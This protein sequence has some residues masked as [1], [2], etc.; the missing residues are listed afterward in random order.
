MFRAESE[1]NLADEIHSLIP[2]PVDVSVSVSHFASGLA[3]M[4]YSNRRTH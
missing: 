1:A 3:L 2:G 4:T